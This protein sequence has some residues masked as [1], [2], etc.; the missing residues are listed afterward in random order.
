MK[1]YIDAQELKRALSIFNDTENGDEHFL[2]GIETARDIIDNLVETKKTPKAIWIRR[3]NDSITAKCSICD[4]PSF[5]VNGGF[6]YC[7]RCGVKME[8]TVV[9]KK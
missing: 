3:D 5:N 8:G 1:T 4:K 2:F 7:P 9:R 6:E